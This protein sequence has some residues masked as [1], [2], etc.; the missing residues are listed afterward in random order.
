MVHITS[1]VILLVRT[2]SNV[3][4]TANVD[5]KYRL[6]IVKQEDKEDIGKNYNFLPQV[7]SKLKFRCF[8]SAYGAI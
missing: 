5:G 1:V 7:A 6:A 8:D 2:V 4:I 3:D